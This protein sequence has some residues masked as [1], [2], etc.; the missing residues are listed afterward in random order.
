MHKFTLLC[1]ML[2]LQLLSVEVLAKVS[3]KNTD[4]KSS[5]VFE[6]STISIAFSTQSFPRQFLNEQ[7]LP[8]GIIKDF[9]TL[10]AEKQQ[11][12]LKFVPL[13]WNETID[14]V[15]NGEIDVHAGLDRIPERE[16]YLQFSASVFPNYSYIYINK[17]LPDVITINQLS[18]YTVGVIK[19]A[20]QAPTIFAANPNVKFVQY[21]TRQKMY[22]A[23]LN[24]EILAFAD[25]DKHDD[26]YVNLS[27]LN[28]VFPDFRRVIIR[29]NDYSAAVVMGNVAMLDFINQGIAK[30]TDEEIRAIETKWANSERQSG[31]LNVAFSDNLPPYMGHSISG[32]PQG[33]YIDIW[34]L[35][36]QYS[37]MPVNFFGESMSRSV[38]QVR[39]GNLDA[40]LA[41][42]EQVESTTGL[43][44]AAKI[45]QIQ[46]QVFVL[47]EHK[48]IT[49]LGQLAGK[50][51]GVF[52][53][54]PYLDE[55]KKSYPSLNLKYYTDHIS[56]IRAAENGEVDAVVSEVENLK[57]KLVNA[58]LQSLFYLLEQP[59]FEIDMFALVAPD[60][61]P[62]AEFIQKGFNAIPLEELQALE[63][64]WLA[65]NT[66]TY[67][68]T[69][70]NQA[71]LTDIQQ[72]WVLSN[73]LLNV[74][75]VKGWEPLEFVDENGQVSGINRDIINAVAERVGLI[76]SFHIFDNWSELF[77]AFRREEVDVILGVSNNNHNRDALIDFSDVYWQ[78][79]WSIVHKQS[80]GEV[81]SLRDFYGKQLAV[82]KGYQIVERIRKEYPGIFITVVESVEE[83]LLAVQQNIVD[84]FI[85]ALPVASK[86]TARESIVP[87]TVSVVP[88]IPLEPNAIAVRKSDVELKAILN[89]GLGHLTQNDKQTIFDRWFNVQIQT[90]LDQRW[91][92]KIATQI[93]FI[94][95]VIIGV[96]IYWNRKLRQEVN[97]RKLLE[98]QMKHMA[99]HDE[100]T[101]IANRNLMKT[102]M[103][104]AIAMHQR[105]NIKLAVLFVDLD[106]F[107]VVNDKYGHDFG[108][109]V[110][111]QVSTRLTSCIRKSDTVCRF[112]GDEFVILLTGLN[113][114]EEAAFIAEKIIESIGLPY[115]IDNQS[116]EL[117]CSIGISM[118]PEDGDNESDLL[119][120]A[121]TLMYRVKDSGKNSYLYR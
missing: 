25:I 30:I 29:A 36:S 41:Y 51:L 63:E 94:I 118:F 99:T 57:V 115:L 47:S 7:G 93:G 71:S 81:S 65:G 68:Q 38:E 19:G 84:G 67:F 66:D 3:T 119:K 14:K 106:G 121:D 33:L 48:N 23:A 39:V 72:Q 4:V 16:P 113:N 54:S 104:Q 18:P 87:I 61:Q 110:L 85:E 112:G 70:S 69:L 15:V 35:W 22:D 100:L 34:R 107:K 78:M 24:R 102:Q 11:V 105:Q 111:K 79:P 28:A 9:W 60:N 117:G 53:T 31:G 80:F 40:H 44:K 46:S 103:E 97:R 58:N 8:D 88:E 27:E 73:S 101:G 6:N 90:G 50:S 52:K 5:K 91:V 10:W 108:D 92:V 86:L 95:V 59:R 120:M 77:N 116:A 12:K 89:A 96:V 26:N 109:K 37:G 76:T 98:E 62:L 114:K 20:S 21:D 2:F 32:K 17:E 64:T 42:P 82:V 83:G 55:I 75:V 13:L 43:V 49:R 74:G 45:H 56:M 1:L